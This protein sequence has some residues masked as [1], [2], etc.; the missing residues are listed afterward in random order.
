MTQLTIEQAM[1]LAVRNHQAGRLAQAEEIYR[2]VLAQ[3]P[4]HPDALHMLGV[5]A[6]QGGRLDAAVELIEQAIRLKPDSPDAYYNL[7][8][9]LGESGRFDEAVFAFRQAIQL[10]PGYAEA[11]NNLGNLLRKNGQLDEANAALVQATRHKA[12]F[13]EA[14]NNLGI[15]LGDKGLLEESVAEF[16]GAIALKPDYAE[17]HNNLGNALKQQDRLDEAIAAYRQAIT[18]NPNAPEAHNNL[19][20][21][22][23]DVGRLDEAIAAFRQAIALKPNFAE[24]Y[25]NLGIAL[26]DKGRF[27]D[28]IAAHNEALRLNPNYAEA[29]GNLGDALGAGGRIDEAVAS[30]RRAIELKPDFAAAHHYLANMLLLQGDFD[31]GWPEYEW[32]LRR[33]PPRSDRREFV[34]PRWD[35]TALNGR[36]ILVHMEGGFGDT[37]QFVR[38]APMVATRGGPVILGCQILLI[39]LLR[40]LPGLTQILAPGEP[41]P[42]FDLHCPMM[43]LPLMFNTILSTIPWSGPYLHA[44]PKLTERWSQRLPPDPDRPRIGLAWAGRPET[45]VDHKRSMRLAD[46]APL[47]AI[48]NARFFSLQKGPAAAQTRQPPAGLELIDYTNDLHDFA[49]TAAMAANLDLILTV[50]TSVAH[51]AGALGRRAWVLL[52]RSPDWR[53]MLDRE[54]SPWYPTLRLFRQKRFGDW[55]EVIDR[56]AKALDVPRIQGNRQ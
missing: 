44:D 6:H 55:G 5:I 41:L 12:G 1:Q 42:A 33:S 11:Y 46:F 25:S 39:N 16:R 15:A 54:D 31:R 37:L 26:H 47:S 40:D 20:I 18:L 4:N 32:R 19:G 48:K 52:P 38:Y 3:Q 29:H 21:A 43:S 23:K 35:G 30:L 13:A 7:G 50:D 2:R 49:D 10:R 51:L 17:A 28:A 45:K 8:N 27:D 56:V 36:T 9:A 53:W 14:H 24:A 22:L 34:Q